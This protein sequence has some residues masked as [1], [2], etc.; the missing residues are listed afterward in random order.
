MVKKFLKL[1]RILLII[2]DKS[3][4]MYNP[5]YKYQSYILSEQLFR[6][7]FTESS[8]FAFYYYKN[9]FC[10]TFAC[11]LKFTIQYIYSDYSTWVKIS[12]HR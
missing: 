11:P 3:S 9:K 2:L 10:V 5:N 4:Y 7:C 8:I 12:L 6:I 1:S